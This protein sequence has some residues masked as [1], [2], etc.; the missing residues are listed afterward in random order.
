M[1]SKYKNL[2]ARFKH[3]ASIAALTVLVTSTNTIQAQDVCFIEEEPRL[4]Q[5]LIIGSVAIALVGAGVAVALSGNSRN[6][7]SNYSSCLYSYSGGLS[8][9]SSSSGSN[10]S[11][12]SYDSSSD[13]SG[14]SSS[15]TGNRG[16]AQGI[17][18]G[19]TFSYNVQTPVPES[20]D[21]SFV[22]NS[23]CSSLGI[24]VDPKGSTNQLQIQEN[25][26]LNLAYGN[27]SGNLGPV[28]EGTYNFTLNATSDMQKGQSI[29]TI[30]VSVPAGGP[31]VSS[32]E[33]YA[34]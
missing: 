11:Y 12:S 23:P 5:N 18:A 31:I 2:L 24:S 4:N 7:S 8:D 25:S 13:H 33:V 26:S 27:T 1:I 10:Y 9:C 15:Y 3:K 22:N 29:G 6:N 19:E 20:I 34:P 30:L 14:S 28:Q 17:L 32:I 16:A 21:F